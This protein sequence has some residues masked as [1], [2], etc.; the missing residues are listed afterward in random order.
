VKRSGKYGKTE[1]L[2]QTRVDFLLRHWYLWA[3]WPTDKMVTE[4]D[5]E[6]YRRDEDRTIRVCQAA[7]KAAG[8]YSPS[9]HCY[10]IHP[11]VLIR[12]ARAILGN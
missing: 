2:T 4:L 8:L 9:T 10:D 6:I 1:S 7:L 3:F 5:S 11:E 12:K